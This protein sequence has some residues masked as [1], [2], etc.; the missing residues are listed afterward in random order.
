MVLKTKAKL[1]CPE[2]GTVQDVGMP[3][4]ASQFFYECASCRA[5]LRPKAGDCRVF[6]SYADTRCPPEQV[7]V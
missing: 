1:T 5:L 4:D 6:C 7:R 3:T 2:C